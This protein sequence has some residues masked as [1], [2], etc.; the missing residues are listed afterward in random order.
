MPQTGSIADRQAGEDDWKRLFP[1]LRISKGLTFA[2]VE[3]AED[4]VYEWD[5]SGEPRPL[6]LVVTIYEFLTAARLANERGKS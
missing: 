3:A 4:L 1:K 6:Q 2:D 5:D